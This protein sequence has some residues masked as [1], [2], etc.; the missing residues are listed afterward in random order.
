MSG[1]FGDEEGR[2]SGFGEVGLERV[3]NWFVKFEV[4]NES[5][6]SEIA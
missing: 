6:V 5:R 3:G 2:G 1:G 4:K